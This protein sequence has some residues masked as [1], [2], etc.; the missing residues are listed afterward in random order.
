ML[1]ALKFH[2]SLNVSNLE[3]ALAFYRVLF[4]IEP[5][6]CHDDY[7]KFELEE[8][9]VVF[10]LVPQPALAG[11]AMSKIGLRLP[12]AEAVAAARQRVLAAGLPTQKPCCRDAT[13]GFVT[14]DPDLN[15]WDVYA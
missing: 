1:T 14:A 6:K 3:R 15:Y 8:P 12:D 13:L 4:G 2:L 7:A 9:P 10:S 11:G 5:A